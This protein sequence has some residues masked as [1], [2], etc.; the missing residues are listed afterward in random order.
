[1][2]FLPPKGNALLKVSSDSPTC[3]SDKNSLKTKISMVHWWK[4]DTGNKTVVLKEKFV[5]MPFCP[6]QISHGLARDGIQASAVAGLR[7]TVW[8]I[9][10][11]LI[12]GKIYNKSTYWFSSISEKGPL[13][14]EVP[15]L[16]PFFLPST[17]IAQMK[18]HREHWWNATWGKMCPSVT[19]STKIPRRTGPG[20]KPSYRLGQ[21]EFKVTYI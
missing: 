6:L 5:P 21:Q 14:S 10:Q 3:L 13:C 18:M 17:E 15:R 19:M 9:K 1:M 4:D 12:H 20:S 2:G 16:R 11:R 7:L 8:V